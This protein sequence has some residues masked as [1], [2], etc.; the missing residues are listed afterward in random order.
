MC[1]CFD[2]IGGMYCYDPISCSRRWSRTRGLMSSSQWADIRHGK[3]Y[4]DLVQMIDVPTLHSA[5]L[6]PYCSSDSWS[7]AQGPSRR[8]NGEPGTPN[9]AF[10]GSYIVSQVVADLLP[11]GLANGSRLILAGSSAGGTGVLLNLDRVAEAL[12]RSAPR[13]EVRGL[14]DSGW[15][16]DRAPYP[17]HVGG[18]SSPGCREAGLY[19]GGRVPEQCAKRFP[20]EEWKCFFGQFVYPSMH[21]PLFVFQWLFDEAQMAAD[22]VG[23]PVS[24]QQWDYIHSMGDSLRR[25]LENVTSVFVPSCISHTVLTSRDWR[26][27]RVS[28]VSL[29]QALR[30]WESQPLNIV[31]PLQYQN[32]AHNSRLPHHPTRHRHG[33]LANATWPLHMLADAPQ[34]KSARQLIRSGAVDATGSPTQTESE[35][36][37]VAS[38]GQRGGKRRR[39]KKQ[40][41]QQQQLLEQQEQKQHQH[42]ERGERGQRKEGRNRGRNREDEEHRPKRNRKGRRGGRRERSVQRGV[43]CQFRMVEKC[44]W[45]Q[46]NHSCPKLHNPFTGE[47]LD[48]IELLKSFGLDMGSVAA[49]LG[50]DLHTLHNMEHEELLNLLTQQAN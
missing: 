33:P 45:P 16:L 11:L 40:R 39:R 5:D 26:H 34:V 20:G 48:F 9:F 1:N 28:H 14:A 31:A 50:I 38:P 37:A 8:H 3:H 42:G 35:V 44:S 15:F 43:Q 49:A 22:N 32:R 2:S 46:C 30:C 27:V 7:G 29:P 25:S 12:R 36:P 41:K 10:M 19:W 6:V 4:D 47:E 21:T 18:A 24:K 23:A 17:G 13:L